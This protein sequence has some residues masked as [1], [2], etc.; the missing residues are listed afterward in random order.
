ML[1]G[2]YRVGLSVWWRLLRPPMVLSKSVN[3]Q[4]TYRIANNV[5][6]TQRYIYQPLFFS[7]RYFD[8]TVHLVTI[9]GMARTK[10]LAV[11][12]KTSTVY[13]NT[14]SGHPFL[15]AIINRFSFESRCVRNDSP[16]ILLSC[17]LLVCV[18]CKPQN[19]Y[20]QATL[21]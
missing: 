21:F 4:C 3:V 16:V 7:R 14:F 15:S 13:G 12:F 17:I 11:P 19:K 10:T 8:V 1:G 20:K 2:R 18:I 6:I 9:L 5:C